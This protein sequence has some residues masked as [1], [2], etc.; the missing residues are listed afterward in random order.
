MKERK[1][2]PPSDEGG[3]PKGRRER[4]RCT[5]LPALRENETGLSPPVS[6]A[7]SPLVRGGQGVSS[8]KTASSEGA[9]GW[10]FK[11]CPVR[12]SH[13]GCPKTCIVS[14]GQGGVQN[15]H[16]QRGPDYLNKQKSR[17]SNAFP[18]VSCYSSI[19]RAMCTSSSCFCS[20]RLGAP[21]IRSW[22]FLFMGKVMTSRMLSSP[23]SSII[24]RSTPGAAPA[25]GGAP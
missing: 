18:G 15:L 17:K 1:P 21:I 13:G 23:V 25:W 10:V 14:G 7:D 11:A 5:I 2:K 24:S 6:F 4:F 16:R 3:G 12:G 8:Q 9:K 20:T 19:F 22:A